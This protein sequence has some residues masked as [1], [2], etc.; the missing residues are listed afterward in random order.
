MPIYEY[1]CAGCGHQLE[2]MQSIKDPPLTQCPK[3]KKNKLRK[4]ISAAGFQ[5]KG[6]GWYVTDFRDKGKPAA[7]KKKE[8]EDVAAAEKPAEAGAASSKPE[9][10][11]SEP[12]KPAGKAEKKKKRAAGDGA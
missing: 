3:C 9:A 6:S 11:S 4:L 8:G 1:A 12:A 2:V 10:P 5:L 7:E